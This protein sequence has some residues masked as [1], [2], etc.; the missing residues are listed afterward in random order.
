MLTALCE[1]G[2]WQHECELGIADVSQR[3]VIFSQ[4]SR[5]SMLIFAAGV[6]HA[7]SGSAKVTTDNAIETNC[8]AFHNI[9]ILH[10]DPRRND[11]TLHRCYAAILRT[12]GF[13]QCSSR[14]EKKL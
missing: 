9:F 5:C 7:E 1:T 3:P 10:C 11:A 13:S 12:D 6:R 8:A 2:P 14:P 4:H